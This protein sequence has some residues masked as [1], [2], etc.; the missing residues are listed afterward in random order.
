MRRTP[1]VGDIVGDSSLPGGVLRKDRF[2]RADYALCE[3]RGKPVVLAF[4]LG[5]NTSLCT[6]Q[7]CSYS[8]GLELMQVRDATVWGISP[9]NIDSHEQF[10]RDRGLRIPLLADPDR[11]VIRSFGIDAPLFGLRRSVFVIAA[12]GSLH[13]KRVGVVSATFPSST[14]IVQQ[15]A[16]FGGP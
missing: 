8:D 15:L 6:R 1:A 11:A 3:Q 12:D 13:W 5:D 14:V 4:Y 2:E 7:L 9:Q 16:A 10:A